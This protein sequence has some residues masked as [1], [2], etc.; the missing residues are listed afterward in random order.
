M[1]IVNTSTVAQSFES[2]GVSP[3]LKGSSS[4]SHDSVNTVDDGALHLAE[5]GV[6]ADI[7]AV[8]EQ[9]PVQRRVRFSSTVV[10]N[11]QCSFSCD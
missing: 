9:P 11:K 2:N 3:T 7:A 4:H 1:I 10:G 5:L 8:P 6:P